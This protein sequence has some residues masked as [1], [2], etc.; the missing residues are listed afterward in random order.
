MSMSLSLFFL[1]C[2][3]VSALVIRTGMLFAGRFGVLDHPGGHKQ[4]DA[5]TPFVGGFGVVAVVLTTL[6]LG[7][8]TT[9]ELSQLQIHTF[10]AGSAIL[11]IT[12]FADDIWH[13]SFKIRFVIQA[14]VASSMVLLAGVELQSL[15]E[16]I[17][18]TTVELGILAV[19]FTIFA[20]V[21]LINALNMID[22]IDGLSGTLSFIGLGFTAVIAL[23]AGNG[24][25][26]TMIIA[27]MGGISGFLYFN[28][29]YPTNKRA[30][31][32]L[33]DNGSMLLGFLFAWLFIALSQGEEA[34]MPPVSALWIFGV[35]LLDTVS[36]MLRRILHGKSPFH[37]DRNHLHH[38]F[39]RAGFRVSDTVWIIALFQIALGA[40]GVFCAQY[41]LSEPI[42][43]GMFLLVFAIYFSATARPWR[44]IPALRRLN[45]TLGLP[46]ADACGVFVGYFDKSS[47]HKMLQQIANTLG[48]RHNHKLSLH[49]I[50]TR[51]NRQGN[52]FALIE[53]D[54]TGDEASVA[55]TRQLMLSIKSRLAQ[56]SVKVRL[57]MHRSPEND[58]RVKATDNTPPLLCEC[59]RQLDR[60]SKQGSMALYETT[61]FAARGVTA[62]VRE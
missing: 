55:E 33:G 13:L 37:A 19:P 15:G 59:S 49:Q 58:R 52:V 28:L 14:I 9:A 11:F 12:G 1:V 2:I 38:L 57:F 40:T 39:I 30:K 5:S 26:L 43:F 61:V 44:F 35:P 50:D 47:A 60:R 23:L 46:S 54:S 20:T 4:H 36:V 41:G 62:D 51:S 32:F 25:Y 34:A 16:L 10:A 27:I 48:D 31:V 53:L 29:R 17:P 6:Y 22:G 8:E 56:P 45:T 24:A 18:G 21:G 7:L 3:I 42:M